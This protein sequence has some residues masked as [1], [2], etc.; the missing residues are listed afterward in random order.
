MR[1]L[2]DT[3][4]WVWA[5]LSDSRLGPQARRAL[6]KLE[7]SERVGL[8]AISLK[9]T[10][11][12]LARGRIVLARQEASWAEWLRD[13]SSVANL[14]ILTHPAEPSSGGN[15]VRNVHSFRRRM[16]RRN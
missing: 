11:W 1:Y 5:V 2:L 14:E 10:A 7:P 16:P 3:H 6:A 15:G 8:A 12:H 4:A 13:A 9:E